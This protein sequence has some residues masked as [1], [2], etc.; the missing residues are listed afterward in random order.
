M[1]YN[2]LLCTENEGTG[3]NG[4]GKIY[5]KLHLCEIIMPSVLLCRLLGAHDRFLPC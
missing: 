5:F 1:L 2:E 4:K 3:R